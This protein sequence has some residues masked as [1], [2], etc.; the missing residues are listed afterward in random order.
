MQ[1]NTVFCVLSEMLGVRLWPVT[2]CVYQPFPNCLRIKR[3]IVF[4]LSPYT[5]CD[6]D[7]PLRLLAARYSWREPGIS[8]SIVPDYGPGDRGS[9]PR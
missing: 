2:V 1:R 4:G 5:L 8:V 7:V 3:Q 9:I 6:M